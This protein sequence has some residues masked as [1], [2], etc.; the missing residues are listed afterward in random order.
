[1]R[2]QF[3]VAVEGYEEKNNS[4]AM[5]V[6]KCTAME[7]VNLSN[8]QFSDLIRN[9]LRIGASFLA[10][11]NFLAPRCCQEHTSLGIAL[12]LAGDMLS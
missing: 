2:P 3:V 12:P 8:L 5:A 7:Y 10:D 9:D 4:V 1:V 6:A 11:P